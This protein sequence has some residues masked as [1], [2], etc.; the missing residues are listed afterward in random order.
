MRCV[1]SARLSSDGASMASAIASGNP[2]SRDQPVA[3]P[4]KDQ[5]AH[6]ARLGEREKARDPRA[7]RIAHH[8]GALDPQMRK[9][10]GRVLR[11][12]LGAVVGGQVEFFALPM[13][14]V[15][16]GD[17]PPPRLGERLDPARLDPIDAMV[18]GEAVAIR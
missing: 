6:A 13:A 9:Q 16:E 11:H 17:D 10:V 18:G 14:A 1:G 7:H 4:A 12:Q 3:E 2:A 15:V 5:R 8:V